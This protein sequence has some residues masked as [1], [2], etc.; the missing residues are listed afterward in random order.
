LL[1]SSKTVKAGLTI[2]VLLQESGKIICSLKLK[3]G[4][5][6]SVHSL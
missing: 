4:V 3:F 2:P 1:N 6:E 5:L